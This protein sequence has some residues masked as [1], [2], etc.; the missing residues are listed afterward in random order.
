MSKTPVKPGKEEAADHGGGKSFSPRKGLRGVQKS[1]AKRTAPQ[2][3]AHSSGPVACFKCKKPGHKA[4]E[5]KTAKF[6]QEPGVTRKQNLDALVI[7][8]LAREQQQVLGS[9]DAVHDRISEISEL[10]DDEAAGIGAGAPP[11]GPPAPA[12]A[13]GLIAQASVE[14]RDGFGEP[15]QPPPDAEPHKDKVPVAPLLHP[16]NQIYL[17]WKDDPK[18]SVFDKILKTATVGIFVA[19]AVPCG[20]RLLKGTGSALT[21][22]GVYAACTAA[23][24]AGARWSSKRIST[25]GREVSLLEPAPLDVSVVQWTAG[26]VLGVCLGDMIGA[27][28]TVYRAGG[29]LR[30]V[31][32]AG[33]SALAKAGKDVCVGLLCFAA[34]ATVVQAASL[35]V[36]GKPTWRK[37][38]TY[39]LVTSVRLAQGY[40]ACGV[41]DSASEPRG[42]ATLAD[43][44]SDSLQ[45]GEL[46][47]NNPYTGYISYQSSTPGQRLISLA[48]NAVKKVPMLS[49]AISRL[50]IK[51]PGTRTVHAVS[52]EATAQISDYAVL[53]P[54]ASPADTM[55]RIVDAAGRLTSVNLDRANMMLGRDV[56][57]GSSFLAYAS[58]CHSRYA[59][60]KVPFPGAST[61]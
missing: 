53:R 59:H 29:P 31:L 11:P 10:L 54:D 6:P 15:R 23:S 42:S 22:L 46:K 40:A 4:H 26:S 55:S 17:K 33:S 48:Y 19:A 21:T 2:H 52:Y 12:A 28:L 38:K 49:T 60:R 57:T 36:Y 34:V 32:R 47:H 61:K 43:S 41:I 16:S 58:W 24:V 39:H 14:W 8:S 5:C 45:R 30:Y 56:L 27:A 37:V 25:L 35:A 3:T 50:R 9:L 1:H 18:A 13:P 44:R 20:W 7:S 51:Q